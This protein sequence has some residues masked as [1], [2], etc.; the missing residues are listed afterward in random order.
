M[1]RL[2][3]LTKSWRSISFEI[4]FLFFFFLKASPD[5]RPEVFSVTE[6][7]KSVRSQKI[8]KIS[9]SAIF[10]TNSPI[11]VVWWFRVRGSSTTLEWLDRKNVIGMY[12]CVV[13][14]LVHREKT[15]PRP[16]I[17][18]IIRILNE[19][20]WHSIIPSYISIYWLGAHALLY[21]FDIP[22]EY[23]RSYLLVFMQR[24]LF[25][26]TPSSSSWL[27]EQSCCC[28]RRMKFSTWNLK[29]NSNKKT[30]MLNFLCF[31]ECKLATI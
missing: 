9:T 16:Y 3:I 14:Y 21:I 28:C 25:Q 4:W 8:K 19:T 6:A 31:F 22:C 27:S 30:S 15:S 24:F 17:I 11:D 26:K 29:G 23:R 10:G 13:H 12:F 2:V 20:W 1:V 7:K 18:Y 5:F